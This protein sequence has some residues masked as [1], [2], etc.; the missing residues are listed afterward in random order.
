MNLGQL[1][2]FASLEVLAVWQSFL[3]ALTRKTETNIRDD[4]ASN[5]KNQN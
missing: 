1:E 4:L 5:L 2:H 3:F